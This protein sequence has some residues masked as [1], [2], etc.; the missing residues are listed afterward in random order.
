MAQHIVRY[1]RAYYDI[2]DRYVYFTFFPVAYWFTDSKIPTRYVHPGDIGDEFF[3]KAMD[4]A[5]A[6][7][8]KELQNILL[9]KPVFIIAPKKVDYLSDEVNLLLKNEIL[10]SYREE[11]QFDDFYIYRHVEFAPMTA[12]WWN[13]LSKT[14]KREVVKLML[15]DTRQKMSG[16]KLEEPHYY[17]TQIDAILRG[18]DE[19][20]RKINEIFYTLLSKSQ[21]PNNFSMS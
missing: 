2:S 21:S 13:I 12:K 19:S 15:N 5:D 16:V 14:R 7:T 3:L 17:V 6:T 4:G 8:A 9:K 18:N 20:G 11:E 10:N 1:F